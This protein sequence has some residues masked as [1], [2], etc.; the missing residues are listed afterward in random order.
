MKIVL[1]VVDLSALDD[2][3]TA[4]RLI[5][6]FGG[7][8]P[9]TFWF[10]ATVLLTIE[11][12]GIIALDILDIG[13]FPEVAVVGIRLLLTVPSCSGFVNVPCRSIFDLLLTLRTGLDVLGKLRFVDVFAPDGGLST[14]LKTGSMLPLFVGACLALPVF[15]G[16][17]DL[18]TDVTLRTR[19]EVMFFIGRVLMLLVLLYKGLRR[20]RIPRFGGSDSISSFVAA[21]VSPTI[22]YNLYFLLRSWIL[23][24]KHR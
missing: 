11:F 14:L 4:I 8:G 19:F 2:F 3:A 21:V 6:F 7:V 15:R 23:L 24:Q 18:R 13:A 17:F 22:I 1:A 20:P 10:L 16:V 5:V 12:V 9:R